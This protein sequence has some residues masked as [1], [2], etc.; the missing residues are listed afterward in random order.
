M[1]GLILVQ[2]PPGVNVPRP[3][4]LVEMFP[5]GYSG[6]APYQTTTGADGFYYFQSVA[7]GSYQIWINRSIGPY[8]VQI[9][10]VP[11]QDIAPILTH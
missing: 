8:V 4:A 6:P 10:P 5:L 7:P 11:N 3:Q 2:V 1:R 9:G